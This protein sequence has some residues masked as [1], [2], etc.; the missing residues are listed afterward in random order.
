[1]H[2]RFE[3]IGIDPESRD[4]V[5]IAQ[6][7][8]LHNSYLPFQKDLYGCHSKLVEKKLARNPYW[9]TAPYILSTPA[10][11]GLLEWCPNEEDKIYE[12]KLPW[13]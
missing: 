11:K 5:M 1:M 2:C 9:R 6:K 12:G 10:I 4:D 8:E 7:K 3:Y 13:D